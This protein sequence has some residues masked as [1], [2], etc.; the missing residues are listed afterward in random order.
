MGYSIEKSLVLVYE[1]MSNG[2]LHDALSSKITHPF[3]TF[4]FWI[5]TIVLKK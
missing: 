4:M 3:F 2:S 5:V 1:F